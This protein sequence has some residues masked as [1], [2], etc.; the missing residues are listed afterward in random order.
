MKLYLEKRGCDFSP[1]HDKDLIAESDL[2][3]FRLFLEFISKDG[4]RVCG[5]IS[6]CD[7]REHFTNKRGRADYKTI[8]RNGLSA[9]M[10]YE[11]H[12]G[13]YAYDIHADFT[14]RYTK[15]D[16]LKFIN[17]ASAVQ[18]D[19]VEIVDELPA[20][21]HDYPESALALEREYLAKDHAKMVAETEALI[22]DSYNAWMNIRWSFQRMT[23]DEYKRMTLLA[24]DLMVEEYG[25]FETKP[26]NLVTPGAF[27]AHHM[28]KHFFEEQQIIDPYADSAFLAELLKRSP[29]YIG[30]YI[31]TVT[32]EEFAA[33]IDE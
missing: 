26:E 16:A 29:Y 1:L 23:P 9:H 17:T 33:A 31:R 21:A 18:Y 13:C 15:A 7:L 19:G 6:R 22:R 4:R 28:S 30:R 2:G 5:D 10:C 24:F 8:S 11:D 14:P 25:V 27:M 12:T 32:P 20:A 3:N